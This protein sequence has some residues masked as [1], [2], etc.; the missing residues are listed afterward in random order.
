MC[1]NGGRCTHHAGS[2]TLG[3][4]SCNC[5]ETGFTGDVCQIADTN[6]S[7]ISA[8][9]T[10][11]LD[12]SGLSASGLASLRVRIRSDLAA[13][14]GV[15]VSRIVVDGLGAGS[16]W[17]RFRILS[18]SSSGSGSAGSGSAIAALQALQGQVAAG[19]SVGGGGVVGSVSVL[20]TVLSAHTPSPDQ[21]TA[22]PFAGD[23]A[24]DASKPA[25][26]DG[27]LEIML[28]AISGGLAAL[29][30]G[31]L[32]YW[33]MK[34]PVGAGSNLKEPPPLATSPPD[35]SGKVSPPIV[36]EVSPTKSLHR[37]QNP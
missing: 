23:S 16:V 25:D 17:V 29:F 36:I 1:R 10:L 21:V 27:G 31:T 13:L 35:G 9:I 37:P 18:E 30:C 3:G 28:F 8:E 20:A 11:D 4:F 6:L 7:L 33:Q 24:S 2:Y 19:A 26:D 5:S 34:V 14:A 22:S 12:V 32:A 15:V